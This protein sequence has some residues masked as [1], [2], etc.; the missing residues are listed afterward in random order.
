MLKTVL[1]LGATGRFGRHA[2]AAFSHAG[3]TVRLFDRKKD[4]LWDA[5]WGADV[6]VNAWNPAYP[7]WHKD[8]PAL[9]ADVIE[10]AKASGATVIIPGNVYVY[11]V[12]APER[13]A[14]ET[15]HAAENP[16]GV[17]RREMEQAYRDA[18]VR[19]IILRAGDF[20][21]TEAS[22]NWFDGVITRKLTKGHVTY[23]G[24][25]DVG[26]AWAYLPD[27]ACAA[28][29]L[30]ARR[31]SLPKFLDIP[32][33]GYTLS[34]KALGRALSEVLDQPLE[35]RTMSWLPLFVARPFWPMAKYLLEMQYLWNK[36]HHLDGATF[37]K[38][39]PH[40]EPTPLIEALASAIN[41][42]VHPHQPMAGG[43][44]HLRKPNF[45]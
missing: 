32:F 16:L 36:P 45:A 28:E 40:F 26:H 1:I 23:P 38:I 24:A 35:V 41:V 37:N 19:T 29:M 17:V 13:F 3:W 7:R 9:T 12:D 15:K 11:G 39:L 5:A 14:A 22:G 30:A 21:D 8:V 33:P 4:T 20:L 43:K 6:I 10:V 18:G 34:G 44:P 31:T 42:D 2:H 25:T 27:L